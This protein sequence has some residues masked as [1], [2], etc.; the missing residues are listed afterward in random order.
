MMTA[1]PPDCGGCRQGRR[2]LKIAAI[3]WRVIVAGMRLLAGAQCAQ[4]ACLAGT[5]LDSKA[6]SHLI[7]RNRF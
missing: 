4:W 5:T 1:N 7:R 3:E 2:C 6:N